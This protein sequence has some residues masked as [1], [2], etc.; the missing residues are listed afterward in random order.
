MI[1]VS[2]GSPGGR[3]AGHDRDWLGS[4]NHGVT[5]ADL[6]PA[7]TATVYARLPVRREK[8]RLGCR[9]RGA[10]TGRARGNSTVTGGGK[11]A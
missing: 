8:D 6:T 2:S 3:A 11:R 10:D 4:S 5:R 9:N 7:V 1:L